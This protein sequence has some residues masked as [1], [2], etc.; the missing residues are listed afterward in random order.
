[1]LPL[2]RRRPKNAAA[3]R[4]R[5]NWWT[6][7][8]FSG[9]HISHL[10]DDFTHIKATLKDWKRTKNS[11]GS[12]FGGSLFA[13]TDP[14]Y[15][16]L[17]NCLFGETHYVWDKSAEIDFIKPGF[18]AVHLDCR[19]S[20]DDIAQIRQ[21]T[22]NGDKYLPEFTVRVFDD[23]GDT[24]A[25]VKRTVYVRLKKEFRPLDTNH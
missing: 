4:R 18:G 15:A 17:L 23:Q 21:A 16:L 20:P 10:S 3:L 14:I 24:V 19:L 13:F 9:I 8:L 12:Q 6:P 25:L 11:H 1:M 7:L 2:P 22:A 5:L